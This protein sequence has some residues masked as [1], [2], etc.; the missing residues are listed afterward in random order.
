MYYFER[1]DMKVKI[2]KTK[3]PAGHVVHEYCPSTSKTE[4]GAS[5]V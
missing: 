4:V 3:E 5:E 1:R 2:R